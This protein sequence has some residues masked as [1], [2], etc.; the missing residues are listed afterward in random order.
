MSNLETT[1]ADKPKKQLNPIIKRMNEF[2]NTV[3]GE[4]IGSKAPKKTAPL[5]RYH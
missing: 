4:H 5:F 3:I 2:R 1:V